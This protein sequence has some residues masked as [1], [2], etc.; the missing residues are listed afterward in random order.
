MKILLIDDDELIRDSMGLFFESEDCHLVACETAEEG[1]EALK[2]Q[3]FDIIIADYRLPGMDGLQF[4][5]MIQKTR[6]YIMKI[7]ITAYG[8]KEL[9]S[10]AVQIG[11]DELLEKPFT[12][13]TLETSLSRLIENRGLLTGKLQTEQFK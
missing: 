3:D 10:E 2:G 5:K 12:S 6:P 11:I 4:F 13:G 8:F 1:L 9:F 7:L